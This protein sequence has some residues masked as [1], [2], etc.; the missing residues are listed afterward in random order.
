MKTPISN[1][2]LTRNE[3]EYHISLILRFLY[4]LTS[5]KLACILP[6]RKSYFCCQPG[7]N[8]GVIVIVCMLLF[9]DNNL[10]VII[11]T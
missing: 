6:L 5:L 2:R 8:H 4:V 3:Y 10:V 7:S 1:C 11:T 9:A